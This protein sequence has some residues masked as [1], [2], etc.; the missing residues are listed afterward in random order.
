[1]ADADQ[2]AADVHPV[3]NSVRA[4][5]FTDLRGIAQALNDRGVRPARCGGLL[6]AA[7]FFVAGIVIADVVRR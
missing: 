5:G 3:V 4:S 7:A 6:I 1:V 2:F